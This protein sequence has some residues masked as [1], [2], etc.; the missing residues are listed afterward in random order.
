MKS[1]WRW[2]LAIGCAAVLACGDE[3][4]DGDDEEGAA[5]G[6]AT[7]ATCDE[8]LTYAKDIAPLMTAYC[9]SCHAVS[10]TG[11]ARNGAPSDHNFDTEQGIL[12]EKSHVDESAGSGPKATGTSMPPRGNPQPTTDERATLSKWLACH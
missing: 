12:A 4:S 9:T 5:V 6:S 2:M 8:S 10:V 11:R 3:D 7:G 1:G